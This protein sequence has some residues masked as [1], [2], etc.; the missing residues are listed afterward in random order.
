MHLLKL[1]ILGVAL[2]VVTLPAAF[3]QAPDTASEQAQVK[4]YADMLRKDIRKDANAIIDQAMSLEPEQ[5]TKFWGVYAGYQKEVK[6]LWDQ[7][8]AN[9][10]KYADNYDKMTD[11]VADELANTATARSTTPR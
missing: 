2:G 3:A 8:G 9:I 5:K 1:T 11:A 6:G 10:K 7:R 4:A